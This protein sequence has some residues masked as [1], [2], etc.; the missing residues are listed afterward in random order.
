MKKQTFVSKLKANSGKIVAII[1]ACFAFYIGYNLYHAPVQ[2]LENKF[3]YLL[4]EYGYIILFFWCMME[5]EMALIMAGILSHATHMHL[6]FAIF[7]AGLGGFAGDQIYFF[8]GRHN[9]KYIYKKLRK[10]RRKFAIAHVLL[11]KHGW[12]IIFMQRY[13][14]G[15]RTVIPM[16]IG[17]TRYSA[18]KFAF[19]NL[20]SA[21]AWASITII[22]AWYLGEEILTILEIA[23]QHWY[24]AIP[25][26]LIFAS[27]IILFFRRVEQNILK[28][29]SK[30]EVSSN[31]Q[32]S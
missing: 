11:K 26:A 1:V 10:Q 30:N 18:Q 27:S 21:W 9:K 23:K 24:V 6:G 16:S 14:Y 25:I 5:G 2:G 28:K 13:M 7:I 20:L 15:L 31:K 17:L 8:I 12:P 32:T 22:P 4:K 19:I 29:R 3:I